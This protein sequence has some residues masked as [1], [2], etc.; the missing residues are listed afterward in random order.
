V[1]LLLTITALVEAAGG[2]A[3]LAV[4]A[5]SAT[6]LLGAPLDT[7]IG[8]TVGRVAG[9]ALVTLGIACWR[10]RGDDSCRAA[11]GIVAAMLFYN[12][13]VAAILAWAGLSE[14]LVGLLLWPAV[15][16]HAV[17][18]GWCLA[19]LLPIAHRPAA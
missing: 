11:T 1:K 13:A 3:L 17:L 10:A 7:Q 4:P 9:A 12:T 8:L 18:A 16:L 6:I 2:V 14:G 5:L 15:I 19:C